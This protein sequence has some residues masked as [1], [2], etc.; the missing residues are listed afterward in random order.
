[1]PATAQTT[2]AMWSAGISGRTG[3]RLVVGALEVRI[4]TRL[5][6]INSRATIEQ[7]LP[8]ARA[9]TGNVC[10]AAPGMMAGIARAVHHHQGVTSR[11]MAARAITNVLIPTSH[12]CPSWIKT[13][14]LP[15]LAFLAVK[16]PDRSGGEQGFRYPAVA[17]CSGTSAR[18]SATTMSLRRYRLRARPS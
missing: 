18:T 15:T 8:M 2:I 9:A 14:S 5:R 12:V 13:P 4:S 16:L 1:M 6:W 17:G 3:L 10:R 7:R 11:K